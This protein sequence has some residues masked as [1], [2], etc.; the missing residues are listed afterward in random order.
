MAGL[1]TKSVLTVLQESARVIES[2]S[3]GNAKQRVIYGQLL[4]MP[5]MDTAGSV[6]ALL[7]KHVTWN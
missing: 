2:R 6:N 5:A 7:F 3:V 4:A 1:I